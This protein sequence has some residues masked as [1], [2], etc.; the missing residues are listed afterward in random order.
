VES[1]PFRWEKHLSEQG[2]G[3]IKIV[4]GGALGE[5]GLGDRELAADGQKWKVQKFKIQ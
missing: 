5:N 2:A 3:R 4:S 1:S